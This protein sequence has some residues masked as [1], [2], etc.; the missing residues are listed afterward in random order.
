MKAKIEIIND[1]KVINAGDKITPGQSALLEKLKMRPFEFKMTIKR[2]MMDGNMFEPQ[3]LSI[4]SEDVLASFQRG[5]SNMTALSLG[6]GYVT[7]M[8][9]PHLIMHSFKNLAAIAFATDYTFPQAE[10]LKAAAANASVAVVAT[11]KV[12]TVAKEAVKEEEPEE[13][14]ADMD[15]GGLFGDD[16]Y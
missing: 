6:S 5:V 13:E 3:V 8:S 2:V 14:E 11:T 16:E 4:T 15:M 7:P 12:E 9:A 10:A 1:V